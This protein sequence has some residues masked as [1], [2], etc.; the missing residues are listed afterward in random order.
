MKKIFALAALAFAATTACAADNSWY[1]GGDVGSTKFKGNGE[2]DTKTG[3]GATVGYQLNT[4]VAFEA[5][6]RRLGSAKDSGVKL[7]VNAIQLSALGIAPINNEFSLFA[8]LGVSRNSLDFTVNSAEVSFHKTKAFFGLG[9]AYQIDKAL[10]LRAEYANLGNN[11]VDVAGV[12]LES[13]IH[14]FNLGLNYAF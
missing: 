13:K 9:A 1:V 6:V 5:S 10:S 4:N 7:S 2:S 11:K 3:F 12:P 8:R 14:Q